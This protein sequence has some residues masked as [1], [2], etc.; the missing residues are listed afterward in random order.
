MYAPKTMRK[1]TMDTTKLCLFICN[2]HILREVHIKL[3]TSIH[4]PQTCTKPFGTLERQSCQKCPSVVY[5]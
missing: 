1:V 3:E 2:I 4:D 5:K